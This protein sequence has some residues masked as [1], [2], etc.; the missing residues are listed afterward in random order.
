M[1]GFAAIAE[2][3]LAEIPLLG[4]FSPVSNPTDIYIDTVLIHRED[5]AVYLYPTQQEGS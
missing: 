3:A 2:V 4:Q 5:T 1:L